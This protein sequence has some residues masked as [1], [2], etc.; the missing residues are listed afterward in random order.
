[1]SNFPESVSG[2]RGWV[3]KLIASRRVAAEEGS[4]VGRPV[5]TSPAPLDFLG[6]LESIAGFSLPYDYMELLGITDGMLEFCGSLCLLGSGDWSDGK[7]VRLAMKVRDNYEEDGLLVELGIAESPAMLFPIGGGGG[8]EGDD[9]IFIADLGRTSLP[10]PIV[11]F[12]GAD[13]FCFR[14]ISDLFEYEIDRVAY[15]ESGKLMTFPVE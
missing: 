6:D 7:N 9:A 15:L 10:G 2:V 11:W 4:S 14:G 5:L 1:M 8:G 3:E 12:R 13:V